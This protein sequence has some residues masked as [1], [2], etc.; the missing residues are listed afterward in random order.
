M[1]YF[2]HSI[3]L[4]L[5][6]LPMLMVAQNQSGEASPVEIGRQLLREGKVGPAVEQL[7]SALS[8][9]PDDAEAVHLRGR[10]AFIDKDLDT[11]I[12]YFDRALVLEPDLAEAYHDRGLVWFGRK[13][14]ERACNDF[15]AAADLGNTKACS[16]HTTLC[17]SATGFTE[18]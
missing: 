1:P 2:K 7:D 13:E 5:L 10:A 11:A 16:A 4:F 15:A 14:T 3:L 8:A 9:N 12:Q 18:D 17:A 6:L